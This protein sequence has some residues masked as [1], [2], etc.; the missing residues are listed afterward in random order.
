MMNRWISDDPPANDE[1]WMF[2]ASRIA[3]YKVPDV[4]EIRAE[5]PLTSMFKLDKAALAADGSSESSSAGFTRS[6][7]L[8][9]S[10]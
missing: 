2:V 9:P 10:K 4:V 7:R 5:L 6:A 8:K 3:D 1:L